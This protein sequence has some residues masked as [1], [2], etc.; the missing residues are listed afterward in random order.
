V[1]AVEDLAQVVGIGSAA[2]MVRGLDFDGSVAAGD[3]DELPDR[4]SG[5]VLDPAADGEGSKADG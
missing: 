5:A 3:A 2:V 4:P 1:D